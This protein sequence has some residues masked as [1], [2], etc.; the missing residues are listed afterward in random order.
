MVEHRRSGLQ[1]VLGAAVTNWNRS[2]GE[3]Y[4]ANGSTVFCDG[5][6]DGAERI[7]GKELRACWCDE[8]GLWR[9]VKTRKGE[10]KGGI[11]SWQESIEFAVREEPG[12]ILATGTPKGKKGVVK[13]LTEEPPDRVA[14]TFPSLRANE[15]NLMPSV[16]EGWR[17]RYGGTRLGRQELEG[18]ILGD[19]EGALWRWEQIEDRRLSREQLEAVRDI[20]Q[21]RTV[22][23]VDPAAS[24]DE[25]SDETGV[26]AARTFLPDID[27]APLLGLRRPPP[28]PQAVVLA[29]ASGTFT[30]TEWARAAVR[31]YYELRADRI[32]A[33]KNN[34][35]EMVLAVLRQID[36][37]VP[38][39]LVWASRGKQTRAEPISALY[40][41]GRVHH[42][43]AL[44]ELESEMTTWVPG[45]QS[46]SRMDAMVWALTDLMLNAQVADLEL[47]PITPAETIT[48]DLLTKQW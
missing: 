45:E 40:E 30:P 15:A 29:D 24:S 12:L 14:F 33:E 28:D 5:A 20:E 27:R 9:V 46:P 23:A 25:G 37:N 4:V 8:I 38:V 2:A 21:R 39:K 36:P 32:V 16:V 10:A 26:V 7:Q 6:D 47:P 42:L 43:E 22:V 1:K 18:E 41:Q 17:R 34:G 35:G 44:P 3:L 48:G 19:V 31:L 11:H 13:L